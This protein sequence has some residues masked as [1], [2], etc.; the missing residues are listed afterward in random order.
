MIAGDVRVIDASTS[1][2][3]KANHGAIGP[4]RPA[5]VAIANV[6]NLH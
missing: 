4:E 3:R 2:P 6:K 1:A 5:P